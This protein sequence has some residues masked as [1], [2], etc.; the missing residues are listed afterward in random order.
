MAVGTPVAASPVGGLRGMIADGERGL[1]LCARRPEGWVEELADRTAALLADDDRRAAMGERARRWVA[2]NL[3]LDVVAARTEALY[4]DVLANAGGAAEI[5]LP[6]WDEVDTAA[7]LDR[8]AALAGTPQ[9][10]A[11][12]EA[13]LAGWGESVGERCRRCTHARMADSIQALGRLGRRRFFRDER[14]LARAVAE[15]CPLALRQ[16]E[17][18][19]RR[20]H[21]PSEAAAEAG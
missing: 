12:G 21:G 19:S 18:A 4:R 8:L 2:E 9:A 3:A 13:V 17:Q 10:R 7:Y 6:V 11:H 14:R 5:A 15:I 20:A 1:L 16:K